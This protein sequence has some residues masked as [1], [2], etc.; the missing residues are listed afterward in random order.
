MALYA[1]DGTGDATVGW[2]PTSRPL[3]AR[4]M[5][6]N[7]PSVRRRNEAGKAECL[8][9]GGGSGTAPSGRPSAMRLAPVG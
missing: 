1:F 5:S 6:G 7:F 8:Q 4:P 3:L 9:R 2:A